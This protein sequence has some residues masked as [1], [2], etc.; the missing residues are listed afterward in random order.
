MNLDDL[1]ILDR[2]VGGEPVG[3]GAVDDS[4]AGDLQIERICSLI[5]SATSISGST[6]TPLQADEGGF[7]QLNPGEC[8]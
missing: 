7:G 6:V 1:A 5:A 2:D 4:A 3:A 8:G